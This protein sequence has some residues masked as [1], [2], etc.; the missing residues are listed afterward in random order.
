MLLRPSPN[1]SKTHRQTNASPIE[2]TQRSLSLFPATLQSGKKG[3]THRCLPF[4]LSTSAR[5][6]LAR[7]LKNSLTVLSLL[8]S[9][10]N[11][12]FRFIIPPSSSLASAS[13]VALPSFL[14]LRCDAI[15]PVPKAV[16]ADTEDDTL[17]TGEKGLYSD[18]RRTIT[19]PSPPGDLFSSPHPFFHTTER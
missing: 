18:G 2:P 14:P 9:G 12:G 3:L 8:H 13:F 15:S 11:L 10:I 4:V 17:E 6:T 16:E 1:V 5:S 19:T 7:V